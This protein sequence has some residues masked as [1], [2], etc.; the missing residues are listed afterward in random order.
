MGWAGGV[1][2]RTNGT[3]TGANV[4]ASDEGA[5]VDIESVRHDTHDKDLA[6]GINACL[7]KDGSN[8]PSAHLSWL[9]THLSINSVTGSSSNYTASLAQAPAAY[10]TGLNF[11]F[12]P[13]HT[14]T[15]ASTIN[16]NSLGAKDIK[17]ITSATGTKSDTSAGH[18]V[19][20]YPTELYYDGTDFI[21]VNP[22]APVW[23]TWTP[24]GY[25]GFSGVTSWTSV[26]ANLQ[27]MPIGSMCFLRGDA[28]GTLAGNFPGGVIIEGLPI[29]PVGESTGG[30][31]H[32]GIAATTRFAGG[33]IDYFCGGFVRT[34][35]GSHDL[36][37]RLSDVSAVADGAM[38]VGFFGGYRIA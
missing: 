15:G 31:V 23:H 24:T 28:S 6:D 1:F 5:G 19:Q 11:K 7:T 12:I 29:T 10:F 27:Y 17:Y 18:I 22:H 34:N 9:S 14:N 26:T 36:Q 3:Y 13:N 16:V 2:S 38:T 30:G 20:G 21:L 33:S 4:W 32:N 8:S 35:S 37:L 25:S